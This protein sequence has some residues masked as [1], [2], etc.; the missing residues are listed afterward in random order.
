MEN[1]TDEKE[2]EEELDAS[3]DEVLEDTDS[4]ESE[5]LSPDS[6]EVLPGDDGDEILMEDYNELNDRYLRLAA[7]YDNYRKRTTREKDDF[8]KFASTS[9]M[10]KL[11]PVLDTAQRG[12]EFNEKAQDIE[13]IKEGMVKVH[14]MFFEILQKEGLDLIDDKEVPFDINLH[15]AVFQEER[16]DVEDSLVLEVF[17]KGYS[18]KGKVLRPAKVKVSKNSTGKVTK[19][20]QGSLS[21]A[22]DS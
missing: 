5:E 14:K 18:Y 22:Q 4:E 10:E 16:E 12:V 11:L 21:E 1:R 7:E 2:F 8:A 15:M 19:P 6:I 13:A 3:V 20:E 17:E 9:L